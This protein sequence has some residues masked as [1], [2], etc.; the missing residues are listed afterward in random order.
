MR[1]RRL[2]TLIKEKKQQRPKKI[3][4]FISWRL[5]NNWRGKR[6]ELR[7]LKDKL[8]RS[9]SE[10][11]RAN[12]EDQECLIPRV[13]SQIKHTEAACSRDL[14]LS[15]I[16]RPNQWTIELIT[17]S[18]RLPNL[19]EPEVTLAKIN[20]FQELSIGEWE[21][22][23]RSQMSFLFTPMSQEHAIFLHTPTLSIQNIRRIFWVNPWRSNQKS[24]TINLMRS[25][26]TTKRCLSL[27]SSHHSQ[28]RQSK[29]SE[30]F[31]W[32]SFRACPQYWNKLLNWFKSTSNER[33]F[34]N[35]K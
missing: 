30:D 10:E 34:Y 13:L 23:I 3:S 15:L 9:S 4:K 6:S 18:P 8:M 19:V 27:E 25:K 29:S 28:E 14:L 1:E 35:L 32:N 20:L 21:W 11:H 5:E 7:L 17:L 22:R 2:S 12:L 26:H 31:F 16:G 24:I 33:K